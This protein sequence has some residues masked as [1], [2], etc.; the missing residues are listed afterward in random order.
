MELRWSLP[1]AEDLDDIDRRPS[2]L[3]GTINQRVLQPLAFQAGIEP[4]IRDG[5]CGH[6]ENV[7]EAYELPTVEDMAV[8]I[9]KSPRWKVSDQG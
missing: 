3:P 2:Q 8:A 9:K 4:R 7:A 5:I 1:A 6:T